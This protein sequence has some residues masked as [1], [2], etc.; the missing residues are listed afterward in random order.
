MGGGMAGGAAL[1][2][3][4]INPAAI[5]GTQPE[6]A[7]QKRHHLKNGSGFQNPWDSFP[8]FKP[9]KTMWFM[10]WLVRGVTLSS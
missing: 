5:T 2:A 7:E 3:L 10:L 4:T 1:Y 6:D 9:I 8:E